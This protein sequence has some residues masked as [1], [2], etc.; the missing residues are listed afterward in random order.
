MLHSCDIKLL[1]MIAILIFGKGIYAVGHFGRVNK[2]KGKDFY[3][4]AEN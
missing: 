3:Q 2:Q 4:I 1:K